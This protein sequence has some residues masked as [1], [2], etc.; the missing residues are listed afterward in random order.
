M[1]RICRRISDLD[2][3]QLM[4]VY[5]QSNMQNGALN[6]PDFS[7]DRQLLEAEQDFYLFLKDFFTVSNAFYCVWAPDNTYQSALR[8]EPYQDG[9]LLEG[10]E[11]V[12]DGRRKGYAKNLLTETLAYV[13]A[14]FGCS[15]YSHIEKNNFPSRNLHISCGFVE[16]TDYAA[17]IDGSIDFKSATYKKG[18]SL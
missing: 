3:G 12:P 7:S 17:Y 6:Y 10:L 4:A 15:I 1:L 2:I 18:C 5:V 8:L 9:L 16:I 13:S 11:T 14:T